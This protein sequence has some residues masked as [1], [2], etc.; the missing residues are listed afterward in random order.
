[1][2]EGDTSSV[3][4]T[5]PHLDKLELLDLD[6]WNEYETYDE[7]PPSCIHYSIEWKVL[8][9]NKAMCKD[10]EHNLVLAPRFYWS[11][12]LRPKLEKF[13][14]R[15]LP[16][17]RVTCDDTSV[18]VS[19]TGRERDLTKRF[20][21]L[22]ID[23]FLVEKQLLTWSELFRAGKKLRIDISF[24]YLEVGQQAPA[25]TKRTGKRGYPSATQQ[26]LAER[27]L[28][29]DAE[30]GNFRQ[31]SIWQEVYNLMRCP[32]PPCHLGPHCWRDPVGKKHYKLMT[33]QLKGLIRYVEQGGQLRSHDDVPEEIRQQLYAEEQQQLE[34]HRKTTKNSM[35]SF[36]PI[37][38]TNVLPGSSLNQP[39]AASPR[40]RLIVPG[41]WDV[42]VEEYTDWQVSQV[43]S[44]KL[45][46]DIQKARD[47]ALEDGLDLRTI[48]EDQDPSFFT[49]RGI[50]IG[51]A[52]RF[53][54]DIEQW[55]TEVKSTV[56]AAP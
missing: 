54:R 26:M 24:N 47:I 8:L 37:N 27:D 41:F 25:P 39:P 3:R 5:K 13:L 55:V 17:R 53:V 43:K 19:V 2:S 18:V 38:I 4:E 9:N 31:P 16:H 6:E 1:M 29:I 30:E 7:D 22:D 44:E 46:V 21:E 56:A 33:H 35:P 40:P 49:E 36:P 48:Y 34:R 52:K 12:Y 45:Q 50:K 42:A 32:G 23:W 51:V 10:T 20:D 15:K 14:Q 11:L 28:Q